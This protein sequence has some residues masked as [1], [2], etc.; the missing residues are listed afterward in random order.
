VASVKKA[1]MQRINLAVYFAISF[2]D[3]TVS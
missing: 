2:F 1:S 3:I